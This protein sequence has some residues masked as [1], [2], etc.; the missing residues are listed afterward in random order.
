MAVAEFERGIIRERV[1]SGLAAAKIRGVRLGRPGTLKDRAQDV[2]ELKA[3]GLGVCAISREL[4]K[5]LSSV[6]KIL[7]LAA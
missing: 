2:A 5:P 6:H 3:Q 7:N 4:K 1:I